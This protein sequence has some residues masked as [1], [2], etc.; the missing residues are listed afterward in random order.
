MRIFDYVDERIA[1]LRGMFAR[2]LK[3]YRAIG[4]DEAEVPLG[5][6][7]LA[8]PEYAFDEGPEY[9]DDDSVD[10]GK[11]LADAAELSTQERVSS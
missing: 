5:F 10:E 3:A 4:Y 9:F 6:E 2:R 7:L 8:D 1:K 11:L